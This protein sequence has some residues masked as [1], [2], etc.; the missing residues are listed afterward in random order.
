MSIPDIYL[1]FVNTLLEKTK[2]GYLAWIDSDSYETFAT[3][4]DGE[5]SVNVWTGYDD[6]GE[7]FI[8]FALVG[9]HGEISDSW[10]VDRYDGDFTLMQEL[11]NAAR[12]SANGINNTI[13]NLQ[14]ILDKK[15]KPH[16]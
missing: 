14:A 5:N 15:Q 11:Y 3:H 1:N 8:S 9:K 7:R 13:Q 6:S 2:S 16:P 4:I 10:Y 12:R